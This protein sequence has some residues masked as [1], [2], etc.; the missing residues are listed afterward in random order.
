[1]GD[2]PRRILRD[3]PQLVTR[4]PIIYE[5]RVRS[6]MDSNGDGIGDFPR[7]HL[8]ARL[9]PGLGVNTLWLLPHLPLPRQGRRL[10]SSPTT[11]T[12][13]PTSVPSTRLPTLRR[14]SAPPGA[15]RHHGAGPEP[16]QRPAPLFQRARR[17]PPGSPE[18][19]FLRLD[20]QPEPLQGRPGHLQ[21]LRAVPTGP[22]YPL[23]KQYY[24]HPVSSPTSPT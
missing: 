9:P 2:A 1:M 12:S 5:L 21:G 22:G 3:D 20:G 14:G 16:H 8:Q 24:W 6:F 15:A 4:T 7:P 18:A 19:R 11:P 13:T 17:A 10:R 23:A